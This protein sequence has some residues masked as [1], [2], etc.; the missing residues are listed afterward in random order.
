MYICKGLTFVVIP[1]GGILQM[2]INMK[3]SI[4]TYFMFLGQSY[5]SEWSGNYQREMSGE[6]SGGTESMI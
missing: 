6:I 2:F 1:S 5:E 3:V 4:I